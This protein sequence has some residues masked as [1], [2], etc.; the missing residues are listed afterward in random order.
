MYENVMM[1]LI[2][3]VPKKKKPLIEVILIS[4]IYFPDYQSN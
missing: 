4:C 3:N 2:K 1:K